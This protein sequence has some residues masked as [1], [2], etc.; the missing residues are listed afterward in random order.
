MSP[1]DFNAINHFKFRYLF[2]ISYTNKDVLCQ[3]SPP[4]ALYAFCPC[5]KKNKILQSLLKGMVLILAL[6]R[7]EMVASQWFSII[8]F[9]DNIQEYRRKFLN[10]FYFFGL[11]FTFP[12]LDATW[13][14]FLPSLTTS[15]T[16]IYFRWQHEIKLK[17]S[18]R[19][20]KYDFEGKDIFYI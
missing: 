14:Q 19:K 1:N 10:H 4:S 13:L 5:F 9:H 3:K 2:I 20:K 17:T 7:I 15:Y 16:W 6:T 12:K 18:F 8:Y 11:K